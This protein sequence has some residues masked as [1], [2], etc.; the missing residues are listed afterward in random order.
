MKDIL[1]RQQMENQ[2]AAELS[3]VLKKL[4]DEYK[5]FFKIEFITIVDLD[6]LPDDIKQL[7]VI[8]GARDISNNIV[9]SEQ[10][11]E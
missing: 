9:E 4:N 1:L 3:P 5:D 6:G 7:R 10:L 8:C 2:V 11:A